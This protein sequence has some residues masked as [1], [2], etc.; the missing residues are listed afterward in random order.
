M[1]WVELSDGWAVLV[2]AAVWAVWSTGCGF[3]LH[4]LPARRLAHD[5][6]LTRI[7]A[8]ERGGRT[9]ER[10]GIRRWKGR[11]PEAGGLFAGG[12]D[13]RHLRNGSVRHLERFRVETRRAELTH[14]WVM[15][16]GPC[17]ALWNRGPLALVML[18]YAVVANL[19]CIMIQRYNRARL[20]RVLAGAARRARRAGAA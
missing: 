15:A 8:V 20:D 16:L 6:W 2:D 19:P 17:F 1:P 11:L 9:Y 7:R 5:G 3:A 12:F 4:R 13:K 14:W 18:A 10:L